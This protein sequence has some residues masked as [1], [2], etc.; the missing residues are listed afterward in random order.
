MTLLAVLLL[1]AGRTFD[2]TSV[3]PNRPSEE[4]PSIRA[5]PGGRFTANGV[6]VLAL[7]RVAYR[8]PSPLILGGPAWMPTE[9]FDLQATGGSG[10]RLRD[11]T[12]ELQALL[13]D[14]FALKLHSEKRE[15]TVMTLTAPKGE[16]QLAVSDADTSNSMMFTNHSIQGRHVTLGQIAT[17]LADATQE[18]VSDQTSLAGFYDFDMVWL[19]DGGEEAEDSPPSLEVLLKEKFG[20][21]TRRTKQPVEVLRVDRVERPSAN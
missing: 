14:R 6:S 17:A 4:V 9:R 15:M 18:P 13:A 20:I 1:L 5:Y 3:K 21:V 2:V 8:I 12:E 19:P 10:S 7:I 16:A 11:M